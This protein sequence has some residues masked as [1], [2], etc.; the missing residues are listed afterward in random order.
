MADVTLHVC[1]EAWKGGQTLSGLVSIRSRAGCVMVVFFLIPAA[2]HQVSPLTGR[3][4]KN[5]P[6]TRPPLLQH[7]S[8]SMSRDYDGLRGW[9]L[10]GGRL[11]D[12]G[13]F[14]SVWW[15]VTSAR[16][17]MS[18]IEPTPSFFLVM[19]LSTEGGGGPSLVWPIV[20]F[21]HCC[22]PV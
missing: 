4:I 15:V 7:L 16:L 17:I 10:R 22:F 21:K 3:V 13:L 14:T 20:R 8:S 9:D 11:G 5:T 18:L 19:I 1:P 12:D 2:H 6:S